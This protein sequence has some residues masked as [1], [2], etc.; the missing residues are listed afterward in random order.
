MPESYTVMIP[1]PM[2]AFG[3]VHL[4]A[5]GFLARYSGPTRD[6]YALDLKSYFAWCGSR[7]AE[8]FEMTRPHIELYVRWMEEERGYAPATTARRLSTVAGF[9]RFAAIDGYIERS[10]AEYVRRPRVPEE[11]QVLGLDRMQLGALVAVAR[12]GTPDEAALISML[13]MMGLRIGEACSANIED[14]GT[15][16]SHRTLHI[17]GKGNKPALI[18]LP[19]PVARTLD[20][21]IGDRRSGPLLRTTTGRRMDRNA[22]SRIV[23]RLAKRAGIQ[24][25]VGCH[26]LRHAFITAA[27]DAGVALRDVQIAARHSD[28]RT[29]IRYDRARGNLDRHA[30]YVVATFLAGAA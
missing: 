2:S 28:P 29:T 11:S 14:M 21:A 15:E 30:N 16:R 13:G 3:A 19:I 10:P 1:E 4:A 6:A 5:V 12:A 27:L 20:A 26:A 23:H 25:R 24:H 9:Y 8:V 22:A 18:P 7:N 17:I